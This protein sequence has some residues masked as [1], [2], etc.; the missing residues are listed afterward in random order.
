LAARR[1]FCPFGVFDDV[2]L[3]AAQFADDRLHAHALHAHAGANAIH[4]AIAALHGD[5]GALSGFPRASF[6][7]H[8]AIVDFRHFL[9]EQTHYQFGS[10]A[11]D[12]HAGTLARFI[13]E[14]D[15]AANAIP[16]AVAFQARLL[17]L[18]QLGFGLAQI[19]HV[20]RTFDALDGAIDQLA[21][22]PGILVEDSFPFGF[23]DFLED[24]LFRGLS[25]NASQGIGVLG[26]FH[27]RADFGFGVD[28]FRLEQR[29]FVNRI[30]HRFDYF[31]YGVE[32]DCPGLRIHVRDVIFI[33]AVMFAG[34][35]QHRILDR[36]QHDLRIDAFFLAQ[37]FDGL[38]DRFQGALVASRSKLLPVQTCFQFRC[39]VCTISSDSVTTQI[40]GWPCEPDRTE[41]QGSG[42]ASFR[43]G[44]GHLHSRR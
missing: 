4:I 10:G 13:H 23:A 32:F 12:Q 1:T 2:D 40:S 24:H 41:A 27:F 34:S 6:D 3:F 22:T 11:R 42:P 26:D 43:A 20:I 21:G 19:E 31:L 30:F 38:K 16:Y 15:H 36:V 25:R 8:G 37:D 44:C 17:L 28:A 5:F 33:R 14:L 39:Y 7:S 18:R 29:H 9:F 35:N